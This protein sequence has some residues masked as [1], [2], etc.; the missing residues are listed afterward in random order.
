VV[1]T[2]IAL[3][4]TWRRVKKNDPQARWLTRK[5]RCFN[6]FNFSTRHRQICQGQTVADDVP[7]EKVS[8]SNLHFSPILSIR[9]C[10][11]NNPAFSLTLVGVRTFE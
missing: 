1:F 4:R 10:R 9:S 2:P 8:D 11:L 5:N 3:A 6:R 7:I